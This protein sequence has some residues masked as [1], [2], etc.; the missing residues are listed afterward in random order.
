MAYCKELETAAFLQIDSL[1]SIGKC[2]F[3]HC[4]NMPYFK[5]P[6]ELERIRT[7]TF[8]GCSRLKF[9]K[10]PKKVLSINH[11]AFANCDLLS[12]AVIQSGDIV[13]SQTA[14]DKHTKIELQEALKTD[15][16]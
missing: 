2:A 11:Q 7:R 6:N 5:L 4:E 3:M 8:Y 9:I 16:M 1:R 14:F 13:I 12:S 10:I 15:N